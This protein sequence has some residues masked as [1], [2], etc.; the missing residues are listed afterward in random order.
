MGISV[1]RFGNLTPLLISLVAVPIAGD[2]AACAH[3]E[4]PAGWAGN[5]RGH[6]G[7][8]ECDASRDVD[9][10]CFTNGTVEWA[11]TDGACQIDVQ[12]CLLSY[13]EACLIDVVNSVEGVE[14]AKWSEGGVLAVNSKLVS[15][16]SEGSWQTLPSRSNISWSVEPGR[17]DWPTLKLCP[18]RS[19]CA[20]FAC[21]AGWTTNPDSYCEGPWCDARRDLHHCCFTEGPVEWAI[22][23]GPCRIDAQGCL[24]SP[25]GWKAHWR[26]KDEAC[27]IDV[28]NSTGSVEVLEFTAAQWA[29]EH[30]FS[31]TIDGRRISDRSISSWQ[32]LEPHSKII[33]NANAAH[34][35][36]GQWKLCPPRASC[37]SFA[38]PGGLA[39]NPVGRCEGSWCDANRDK[40]HCCLLP[41]HAKPVKYPCAPESDGP[42]ESGAFAHQE[43]ISSRV[44]SQPAVAMIFAP[45]LFVFCCSLAACMHR[46]R[47]GL[48]RSMSG[49]DPD[50]SSPRKLLLVA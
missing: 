50:A 46:S 26:W 32:K 10:C 15:K 12:G 49:L 41:R 11:V 37:A 2:S 4:C 39:L 19:S 28:I 33:W 34:Y 25:G 44:L 7:G 24:M 13:G 14:V 35:Y 29:A 42:A 31:L 47:S 43:R 1:L 40:N 5:A 27:T 23:D 16:Q 22:T 17:S 21:P 6:C 38:C 3:F 36:S 45:V 18:P 30:D 9:H 48:Q 20:G 8:A